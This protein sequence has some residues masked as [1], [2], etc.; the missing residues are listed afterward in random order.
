MSLIETLRITQG[1]KA[2]QVAEAELIVKWSRSMAFFMLRSEQL[3][4]HGK[5]QKKR[6]FDSGHEK[7]LTRTVC[8]GHC[9]DMT[10]NPR[11]KSASAMPRALPAHHAER[12]R[13]I[14]LEAW[15]SNQAMT[16]RLRYFL[17][18]KTST[19]T[20]DCTNPP[21]NTLETQN[22]AISCSA[23]ACHT[24][25]RMKLHSSFTATLEETA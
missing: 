24:Y 14:S 20:D 10:Q 5:E 6:E 25:K 2:Q 16:F 13:W 7:A 22:S 4:V 18:F 19:L 1:L 23:H 21:L 9:S 3:P 12:G 15:W 8:E 11:T 17:L